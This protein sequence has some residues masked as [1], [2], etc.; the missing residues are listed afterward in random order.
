MIIRLYRPILVLMVLGMFLPA[1]VAAEVRADDIINPRY[2]WFADENEEYMYYEETPMLVRYGAGVSWSYRFVYGAFM[3]NNTMF[4]DVIP[5]TKKNCQIL[6]WDRIP[7][8][9]LSSSDGVFRVGKF[10]LWLSNPSGHFSMFLGEGLKRCWDYPSY[11]MLGGCY[12]SPVQPA[13][14]PIAHRGQ[15]VLLKDLSLIRYGSGKGSIWLYKR[16]WM[17]CDPK[18]FQNE[19]GN[20]F[21]QRCWIRNPHAVDHL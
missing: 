21:D 17:T 4:G 9:R 11:Q 3:C 12:G 8:T 14:I 13:W 1:Q 20:V 7:A 19:V 10:G 16:N 15:T 5:G 6:R 18:E 2:E